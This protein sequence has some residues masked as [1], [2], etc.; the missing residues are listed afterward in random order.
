MVNGATL[1]IAATRIEEAGFDLI[2]ATNVL[3][4]LDDVALTMAVANMSA[5]LAPGGILLHNESRPLMP[6]LGSLTGLPLK[7]ARTATI[8]T[9]RGAKPLA[10][11]VWMHERIQNHKNQ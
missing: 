7:H 3:P 5:M 6:E 9:V 8:A 4:Y 10:D 1:D 2:V 11:G